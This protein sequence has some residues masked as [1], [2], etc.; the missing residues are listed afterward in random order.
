MELEGSWVG[1]EIHEP[2]NL[3]LLRLIYQYMKE[4]LDAEGHSE[5]WEHKVLLRKKKALGHNL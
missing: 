4:S 5:S 3:N 2:I 1:R